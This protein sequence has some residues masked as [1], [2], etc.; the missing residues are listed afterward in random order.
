MSIKMPKI[1]LKKICNLKKNL[2]TKVKATKNSVMA[3]TFL[4]LKVF[5]MSMSKGLRDVSGELTRKK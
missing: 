3:A 1:I 4:Q 2:L 5:M